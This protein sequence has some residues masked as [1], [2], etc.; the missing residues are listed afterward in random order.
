[1]S[2][3]TRF[4]LEDLKTPSQPIK[5]QRYPHIETSHLICCANQLTGFYMRATL[6][7]NGLSLQLSPS[8]SS[9]IIP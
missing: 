7:L 8:K 2:L 6:G 4:K 3:N 1:M 5:C 9:G